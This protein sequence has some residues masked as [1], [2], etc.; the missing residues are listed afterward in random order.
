ME[1]SIFSAASLCRL[2]F[3]G[4][5][6]RHEC[7][8]VLDKVDSADAGRWTCELE[9]YV[10]GFASGY[11]RRKTLEFMVLPPTTAE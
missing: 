9:S 11:V 3:V 10:F 1:L 4:D 6:E 2:H 8:V 5:Y 7:S